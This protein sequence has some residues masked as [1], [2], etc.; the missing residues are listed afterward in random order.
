M[1]AANLEKIVDG[2]LRLAKCEPTL[3]LISQEKYKRQYVSV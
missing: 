1:G 3:F 2:L